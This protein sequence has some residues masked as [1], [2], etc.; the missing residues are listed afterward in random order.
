MNEQ[1]ESP[2]DYRSLLR[3]DKLRGTVISTLERWKPAYSVARKLR[4]AWGSLLRPRS[5]DG[6]LGRVHRN[7]TMLST[8]SQNAA[9]SYNQVGTTVVQIL[10]E[11]IEICNRQWNGLDKVLE[12][13]CNYGR[14]IRHLV[15]KIDPSRVY[16]CDILEEGPRFC[17]TEFKINALPPTVDESFPKVPTFDLVYLLSVFTHLSDS[18]ITLLLQNIDKSLNPGAV[19]MFSIHG[20]I[21]ASKVEIY[22]SRWTDKKN[23]IR[24]AMDESGSYFE[25]YSYGANSLGMSW[26]T[27]D[28]VHD[29]VSSTCPDL[30][31]RKYA[32]ARIDSH[33]DIFVFQKTTL[34]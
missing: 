27:K 14:I 9:Q 4:F 6:V 10:G 8:S 33:Q 18:V 34:P 29:I 16:G 20:P 26:H 5:I 1:L 22:G 30:R 3:I 32:P 12:V 25:E 7:D 2:D 17:A 15:T 24:K 19:L 23:K 21:S 31:L 28:R 13:G 11:S